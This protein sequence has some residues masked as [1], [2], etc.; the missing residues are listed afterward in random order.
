MHDNK[1]ML[2]LFIYGFVVSFIYSFDIEYILIY[3]QVLY[4]EKDSKTSKINDK[5][6]Y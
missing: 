6:K 2:V 5:I 4:Y 3:F 1:N